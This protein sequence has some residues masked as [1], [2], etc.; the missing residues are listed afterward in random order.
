MIVKYML[1]LALPILM[2]SSVAGLSFGSYV[3]DDRSSGNSANFEIKVMNLGDSTI[4]V[5]VG[6]DYGSGLSASYPSTVTLEPSIATSDPSDYD[7]D[8]DW[9]L[10]DDGK[11]VEVDT[12]PVAINGESGDHSVDISL[13]AYEDSRNLGDIESPDYS[14]AQDVAQTRTYTLE[15]S[16]RDRSPNRDVNQE[17]DSELDSETEL[18]GIQESRLESLR[19]PFERFRLS[20]SSESEDS[21]FSQAESNN[22]DSSNEGSSSENIDDNEVNPTETTPTGMFHEVSNSE[23]TTMVLLG[24]AAASIIYLVTILL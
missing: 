22:Q 17:P 2:I 23:S 4:N 14:L 20:D 21:S 11:Y 9:F 19:E 5:D 3:V 1:I 7:G 12:I 10:L 8:K 6:S 13:T 15:A 24:G 16:L 18:E